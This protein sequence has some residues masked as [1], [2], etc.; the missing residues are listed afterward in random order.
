[1]LGSLIYTVD[2]DFPE[3]D[4]YALGKFFRSRERTS[5]LPLIVITSRSGMRDRIRGFEIGVD[6]FISRPFNDEVIARLDTLIRRS[7]PPPLPQVETFKGVHITA[8]FSR[9]HIEVGG[10][11]IRLS[12]LEF[13]LLR[14][15]IQARNLV[16][17]RDDLMQHVW[18][19]AG[20]DGRAVDAV[21]VRLR[22]KLGIAGQ[23]IKTVMGR[24]YQFVE[25]PFSPEPVRRTLLAAGPSSVKAGSGAGSK[26]KPKTRKHANSHH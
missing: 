22:S 13:D 24:G 4:A 6:D 8:D 26:T 21:I 15:F 25:P 12:R 16:L 10:T 9:V 5:R 3:L 2:R 23:Q 19:R 14:F 1:L 11:P 7:S 17:S 20:I 18:S